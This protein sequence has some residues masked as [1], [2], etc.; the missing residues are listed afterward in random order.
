ML[1]LRGSGVDSRLIMDTLS[2]KNGRYF[3]VIAAVFVL[4]CFLITSI[5]YFNVFRIICQHQQGNQSSQ[6]LAQPAINLS[7]FKKSV[8][9]ILY[10]IALFLFSFVPLAVSLVV[11][12]HVGDTTA[13]LVA[14]N[15]SL[16]CLFLSSSLNPCLSILR[17]ND[18]RQGVKQLL[19][20]SS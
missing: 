19:H 13:V 6:N 3:S 10:V 14:F 7:K 9:S 4:T 5:A 16:V 17:M 12:I 18:V 20:S 11:Y 8:Y 2:G 1:T 15:V